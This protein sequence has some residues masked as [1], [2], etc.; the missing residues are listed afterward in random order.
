MFVFS[1]YFIWWKSHTGK[2]TMKNHTVGTLF[3]YSVKAFVHRQEAWCI[4]AF[5]LHHHFLFTFMKFSEKNGGQLG[6]N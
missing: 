4:T 3:C 5:W 2:F 1:N 6:D